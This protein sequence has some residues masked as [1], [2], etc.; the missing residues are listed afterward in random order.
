MRQTEG[1]GDSAERQPAKGRKLEGSSQKLQKK[2][3]RGHEKRRIRGLQRNTHHLRLPSFHV[4]TFVFVRHYAKDKC[5]RDVP[6]CFTCVC[7][8]VRVCVV[9]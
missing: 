8:C 3:E 4:C 5:V 6:L 9:L 7:V 1:G 2:T